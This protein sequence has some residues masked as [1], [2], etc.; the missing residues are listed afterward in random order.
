MDRPGT[1]HVLNHK[2][3]IFAL[4][5]LLQR[6][7]DLRM[8]LPE[9]RPEVGG[10]YQHGDPVA[11]Q[12]LLVF[13]ISITGNKDLEQTLFGLGDQFAIFKATPAHFLRRLD[14]MS[15]QQFAKRPRHT[16]V[17]KDFH[18][19]AWATASCL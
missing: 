8:I 5:N 1:F 3:A 16:L 19:A 6:R 11:F 2:F 4:L 10:Q 15:G 14:F 9:F 7:S 17:E 13:E 18:A 12:V